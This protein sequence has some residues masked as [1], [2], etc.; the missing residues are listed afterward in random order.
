MTEFLELDNNNL[1]ELAVEPFRNLT[2]L[3]TLILSGNRIS[4]VSPEI[5]QYLP[6]LKI[7]ELRDNRLTSI[8]VGLKQ[9]TTLEKLDLRT[10]RI[11]F[12]TEKDIHEISHIRT[13]DLSRNEIRIWPR[14][15]SNFIA[16]NLTVLD[17]AGNGLETLEPGS[18]QIFRKLQHL[19]LS[20]N[21]IEF[22]DRNVFGDSLKVLDLSRNRIRRISSLNFASQTEM[23]TLLLSR[24]VIE[25]IEAG[26][27]HGIANLQLLNLSSNRLVHVS[28]GLFGLTNLTKLDLSLNNFWTV[29]EKMWTYV[30][31][32]QWLSLSNNQIVELKPY[33][34]RPLG[35]LLYLSLAK[36]KLK[37]VNKKSL[38]GLKS[39]KELNVSGNE[40]AVCVEEG[41]ILQ[42][43]SLIT[44]KKLDFSSN[45]INTIP[46]NAFSGF[47]N[48]ESIDLQDNPIATI[49]RG[50]FDPLNL[51]E[52]KISTSDLICDCRM[53]WFSHWLV[54]S[55]L[56]TASITT[57]CDYPISTRQKD[58][59]LIDS[60]ELVCSNRTPQAKIIMEPK[61]L[62]VAQNGKDVRIHCKGY[63][64]SPIQIQWK[65]FENE[66]ER[67]LEEDNELKISQNHTVDEQ[68]RENE[69]VFSELL[70]QN[71]TILDEAE[72]QCIVK[73]KLG[74]TYSN[75][76]YLKIHDVPTFIIQPP[77]EMAVVVGGTVSFPCKAVGIPEPTLGFQ[78]D[79]ISVFD[80]VREKR[81]F[82]PNAGDLL[83]LLR[84]NPKDEGNYTCTAQN[85]AG[86]TSV[87]TILR[88]Y[89]GGF[90]NLLTDSIVKIGSPLI[91]FCRGTVSESFIIRWL[92]ND[93]E[94]YPDNELGI[95][96]KGDNNE[97][98]VVNH[99]SDN[100]SGRY[101]CQLRVTNNEILLIEQSADV[102]IDPSPNTDDVAMKFKHINTTLPPITT[103]EILETTTTTTTTVVIPT[104]PMILTT[105]PPKT[106][107]TMVKST[108]ARENNGYEKVTKI[109][110]TDI[111]APKE[112]PWYKGIYVKLTS[113][114]DTMSAFGLI[115]LVFGCTVILTAIAGVIMFIVYHSS[116]L[117]F[118]KCTECCDGK[119]YEL[120]EE[121]IRS[122]KKSPIRRNGVPEPKKLLECEQ[123]DHPIIHVPIRI[124]SGNSTTT[125]NVSNISTPS[126]ER[127]E[128]V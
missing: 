95:S 120:T 54:S 47:R 19:R 60:T 33:A 112:S 42:N 21:K 122:S 68:T 77:K 28:E 55:G 79:G 65:V 64:A 5:F 30:E 100:N 92:V 85:E 87:S 36:N 86:Q 101:R 108:E 125:T 104:K 107:P 118:R 50:A 110:P 106:T 83:Y 46:S 59:R 62:I 13:V 37:N 40:L 67:F 119:S 76:A 80:A 4:S 18:F 121:E 61:P 9:L 25:S 20:R 88:V 11:D 57:K 17:L 58:I 84:V 90:S 63:G 72:Y 128:L 66:R 52:L 81:V 10:N 29:T 102:F 7:L 51:K 94:I 93:T 23:E 126:C 82:V 16:S 75:H 44:L 15:K 12:I 98:L 41:T 116:R 2:F 39:L 113:I 74:T 14:I 22:V 43:T 35:R 49:Y 45:L 6:N 53:Q 96:F 127:E 78:K 91:L 70:L 111:D 99:A 3:R 56:D 105:K 97:M 114:Y 27:F 103:I 109:K 24:N 71:V 31:N 123:C 124:R 34:F 89:E 32:L 69:Y 73:N 1:E 26:A 38:L 48:L 117:C 8:P 115:L